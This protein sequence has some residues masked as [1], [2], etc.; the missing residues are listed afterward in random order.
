MHQ[1]LRP[2]PGPTVLTAYWAFGDGDAATVARQRQ[3]LLGEPWSVWSHRVVDDLARAHPDLPA[4]T[5]RV[6]LMRYG[7]A[8]AIPAPGVRGSAALQALAQPQ[9][10]RLHF[11]HSDLAGYSIFEEAFTL[12]HAAGTAAALRA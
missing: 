8:M 10:S 11:A 9:A 6:D 12:G 3:A 1:S 7:H 4:K 5:A 2:A